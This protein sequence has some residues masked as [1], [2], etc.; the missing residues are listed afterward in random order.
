MSY[1]DTREGRLAIRQFIRAAMKVP[2]LERDEEQALA[3]RWRDKRDVRALHKLVE[4]HMR[5]VISIA[6][7]YRAYGLP[8]ADLVQEGNVG[9]MQ[10]AE[11]FDPDREV[12]FS[13]YAGWWIRSAIQEYVLRNWSIVRTGTTAAQKALFFNLRR[14]QARIE[15]AGV[16]SSTPAATA[17]IARQLRVPT[18][19]VDIMRERLAATDRSLNAPL[20]DEAAAEW[21]D[22]LPD[23]GPGP[24]D[25]VRARHDRATRSRWIESA[26]AQLSPREQTIVRERRLSESTRTLESL[27]NS[28]GISKERVRQIEQEALNKLRDA[29]LRQAGDLEA[30]TD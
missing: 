24:E 8:Q 7:R 11:R 28:L 19:D 15:R 29:I 16:S 21:Q 10:A 3:R 20:A 30:V 1:I 6:T 2:L 13:T 12:R 5:L 26:L 27:G 23:E 22:V 4:P 17:E 14:L 18:R 25:I 9:L